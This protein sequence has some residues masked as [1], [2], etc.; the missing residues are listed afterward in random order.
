MKVMIGQIVK[1]ATTRFDESC[2]T[3]SILNQVFKG[4]YA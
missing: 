3:M 2:T 1:E 4:M